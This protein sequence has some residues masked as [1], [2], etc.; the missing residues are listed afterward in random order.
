MQGPLDAAMREFDHVVFSPL[1]APASGERPPMLR[2]SGKDAPLVKANRALLKALDASN[3]KVASVRRLEHR[4]HGLNPAEKLVYIREGDGIT[5]VTLA[6]YGDA[7]VSTRVS[8]VK[9]HVRPK[10]WNAGTGGSRLPSPSMKRGKGTNPDVDTSLT[11][12]GQYH[13]ERTDAFHFVQSVELAK[14]ASKTARQLK[15]IARRHKAR[16]TGEHVPP[17]GMRYDVPTTAEQAAKVRPVKPRKV[18]PTDYSNRS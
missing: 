15:R 13:G 16:S 7:P 10:H 3:R 2:S 11:A 5:R 17:A 1:E 4:T 18:K 14:R 9:T 8:V 6:E 12:Y